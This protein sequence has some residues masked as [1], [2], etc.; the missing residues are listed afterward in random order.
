MYIFFF[1]LKKKKKKKRKNIN[2]YMYI[3]SIY[4]LRKIELNKINSRILNKKVQIE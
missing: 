2:I 1:F 4:I 3:S